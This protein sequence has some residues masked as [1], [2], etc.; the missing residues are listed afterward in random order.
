[1]VTMC[2]ANH[3]SSSYASALMDVTIVGNSMEWELTKWAC[4]R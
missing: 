4:C 1:M 2:N 3:C